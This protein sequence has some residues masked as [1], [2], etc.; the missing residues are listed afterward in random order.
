MLACNN[1]SVLPPG[2]HCSLYV[3]DFA[4]YVSESYFPSMECRLQLAINAVVSWADLHGFHFSETKFVDLFFHRWRFAVSAPSLFLC[5]SRVRDIEEDRFLGLLFD[6]R[7]SAT[8]WLLLL[9]FPLPL[10]LCT[11]VY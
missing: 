5:D 6:K 10:R 3:D 9:A 7:L 4:I 11:C 8:L 1:V 2:I